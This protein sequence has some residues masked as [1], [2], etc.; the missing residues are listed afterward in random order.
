MRVVDYDPTWSKLF[1]IE[2]KHLEEIMTDNVLAVHH[3]GSTAIPGIKAK[4]VIDILIEVHSL[5]KVDEMEI[6]LSNLGYVG[7]GENG[8][9]DRRFFQKGGDN[10]T[11]HVHCYK[12]GN[13]EVKR[14]ILFRD[15][16]R[17][18]LNRALEY[19]RLKEELSIKFFQDP[20]GYV[21]G[22]NEFVQMIDEK[23]NQLINSK[24]KREKD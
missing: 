21:E 22:K 19:S 3:I 10:R 4:P 13:P 20:H 8:I 24:R 15:Y 23:V 2:K 16:L 7:K 17:T 1:H 11:H 5:Q 9:P 14:H 12:K 18:H 6:K